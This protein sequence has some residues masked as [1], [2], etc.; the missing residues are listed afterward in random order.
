MVGQR[1][2]VLKRKI[3]DLASILGGIFF[4]LEGSAIL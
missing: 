3:E 4:L 2:M 1:R